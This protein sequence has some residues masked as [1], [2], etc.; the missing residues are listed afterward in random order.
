MDYIPGIQF[1]TSIIN[2]EKAKAITMNNQPVKSTDL[3]LLRALTYHLKVFP[4]RD[5][6]PKCKKGLGYESFSTREEEGN[7]RCII[8]SREKLLY[9]RGFIDER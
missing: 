7:I 8:I 9:S 3:R 4:Y 1:Q 6:L 5:F 2:M